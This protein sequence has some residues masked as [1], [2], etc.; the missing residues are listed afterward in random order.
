MKGMCHFLPL[1]RDIYVH[2]CYCVVRNEDG[3]LGC[4]Y[5]TVV[6]KKM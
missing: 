2:V 5:L 4:R 3:S 1:R 6:E